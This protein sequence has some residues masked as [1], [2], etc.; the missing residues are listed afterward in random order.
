MS[1][2]KKFIEYYMFSEN[3]S[4]EARTTNM[5]CILGIIG[6]IVAI[7]TR[8]LMRSG[9][10]IVLVLLCIVV[11]VSILFVFCN[12]FNKHRIGS[13]LILF[14]L[15]DVLMPAALF[16][17]GGVQSGV[18]S[19]FTMS[20]VLIFV[21][22]KGRA[23]LIFLI[24]HIVWVVVCYAASAVP[25]FDALVKELTGPLQYLD[26]IQSLIVSGLFIS[27]IVVFQNRIFLKEKGKSDI[28]THSMQDIAT[29]LFD[30][31]PDEPETVLRDGMSLAARTME[32]D[33]IA[34]WKN[35]LKDGEVAFVHEVSEFFNT[36]DA[37]Y[38]NISLNLHKGVIEFP[39]RE[40]LPGW[41]EPLS[42]GQPVRR[43]SKAYSKEERAFLSQ[44]NIYST[45]VFPVI[46]RG[47]FWGTVA[48]NN[49]HTDRSF[50]EDEEHS[51]LPIALVLA[52]AIIRNE[53]IR[54]LVH[55][56]DEAEAASRAKS[57]FL[58]N[59]SHEMRTPMNAII[60]MTAIGKSADNPERKNYAFEKIEGASTHLLGVINDVLDMSKIEANK[61]ELASAAF[62]LEKC[63]QKAVGVNNFRREE[64]RQHFGLRIDDKIP[65]CLLGDDQ[66]LTQ[67][68]TNLLSNAIKFTPEG[69]SIRLDA[70]L[71]G[72]E[73]G[74]CTI[75]IAVSDTGIGISAQQQTRLFSAFQQAE[76]STSRE[77]GGTGLGLAI[78]K[79]IVDMM[80]GRIWIESEPGKGSTFAFTMRAQRGAEALSR[81]E[82]DA[83]R[84]PAPA[85]NEERETADDFSGYRVLLA[86]DIEI[87]REVVAALLA[88][89]GLSMDCAENG[90]EAVRIFREAPA[91]YDIIFM[92][93]QMPKVDGYEATRRIRALDIA[94]AK[95]I[96]ILAMTANVFRDDVE[97]CLEA[98]MN[99]HI[100]KPLNL[101]EVLARLREYLP[102]R[103][104]CAGLDP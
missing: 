31:N 59:M 37:F 93:L 40:T 2:L 41:Y 48:F 43:V 97:R 95:E 96:P 29:A 81:P 104:A 87:N 52:N 94:R 33:C 28:L 42:A 54:D 30:L 103:A 15:C 64:K 4:L 38:E 100:G 5:V 39:Y 70:Y 7:L 90:A 21:L 49:C 101:E 62:D 68:V 84:E 89:T 12:V 72:E 74:I 25:P 18:S 53:M 55:A 46:F 86:E 56:Q 20:V 3:L 83:A 75:R 50:S 69:G 45:L 85:E 77:F 19:Y 88:P 9:L 102:Q 51:L 67:V 91:R 22:S 61:L 35:V 24:T 57:D 79:R 58:S 36:A 63:L 11:S 26:H 44:F 82:E 76:N 6:V 60:G 47:I 14:S 32:I 65:R 80:G 66:R 71:E 78:S 23:R 13:W 34:V 8:I 98:G 17:M 73:N 1:R 99:G 92:D 16:A 10:A 27:A